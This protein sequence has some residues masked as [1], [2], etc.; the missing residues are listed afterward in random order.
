MPCLATEDPQDFGPLD[1]ALRSLPGSFNGV[2]LTSRTAVDRTLR[3]LAQLG[4]GSE[5][6]A[7]MAIGVAGSGTQEALASWDLEAT[8]VPHRFSSE[9]L[10]EGLDSVLGSSLAGSRW[11]LPRAAVAREVL[12]QGLRDRGAEVEVVAAYSTVLPSDLSSL[13]MALEEGLD[14]ITFASGSA[15]DNLAVAVGRPL[16]DALSGISVSAIGPVT[17]AR[18]RELGLTVCIEPPEARVDAWVEAIAEWASRTN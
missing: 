9:G 10:L 3:R 6:L 17:S 2:L 7:S 13:F 15:V 16:V 14:L 12:P 1:A 5:V 8:V 11:L 18:C 4:I